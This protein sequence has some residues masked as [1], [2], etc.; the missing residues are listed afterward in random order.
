MV[1]KE[2]ELKYPKKQFK[3]TE[4]KGWRSAEKKL[5]PGIR[6]SDIE[7]MSKLV[8]EILANGHIVSA[9]EVVI[10]NQVRLVCRLTV[11]Y[12]ANASV[13]E[14]YGAIADNNE[15][16]HRHGFRE[17]QD[18]KPLNFLVTKKLFLEDDPEITKI[19]ALLQRCEDKLGRN[20][21]K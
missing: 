6:E 11:A 4:A 20:I 13:D 7:R 9:S 14:I 3:R 17:D 18:I 2:K 8:A 19:K 16:L 1:G 21:Q 5:P 10:L 15:E 12:Q